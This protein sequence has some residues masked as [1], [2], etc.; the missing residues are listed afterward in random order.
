MAMS[1]AR[2]TRHMRNCIRLFEGKDGLEFIVFD[3]ESTGLNNKVDYIVELAAMRC[4]IINNA[5]VITD[6]LDVFIKPPFMMDKKVID[7]HGI[8]NEFLQ[9]KP[10]ETEV[11]EQI[12]SFFGPYPIIIGYNVPFDIG[13]VEAMYKRCNCEFK[14][15]V[16]LD[17]LDMAR[18]IVKQGE[19]EDY[20]LSTI[21]KSYGLDDKI[22]FHSAIDDVRATVRILNVF[23][24]E[25]KKKIEKGAFS[26]KEIVYVNY[27]YFWEGF[28]KNQKGIYLNTNLGKIYLSTY[29]KCWCSSEVDL[30]RV[31]I[32]KM[33]S[34]VISR[35][36]LPFVEL[37]KMTEK[38]WENIK[39][40]IH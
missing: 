27:I 3:V 33:E 35:T 20:T 13:M 21:T 2:S 28:N 37:S 9:D 10:D 8:S 22:T 34:E 16:A 36:G 23:Y 5:A 40:K 18:D 31:D 38:K 25:Y 39:N 17:V 4:K 15:E 11:I 26:R 7:I 12:K 19:T 6:E 30:N 32:D 24:Q 29:Q 1:K 14:Y